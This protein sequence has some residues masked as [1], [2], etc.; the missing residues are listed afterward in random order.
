MAAQTDS[1]IL[2][3]IIAAV[4]AERDLQKF[5]EAVSE[6]V[7]ELFPE[8]D[9]LGIARY[10][11]EKH[12][13]EVLAVHEEGGGGTNRGVRTRDTEDTPGGFLLK[14]ARTIMIND[15]D[16]FSAQAGF[17]PRKGFPRKFESGIGTLLEH[18]GKVLGYIY[19]TSQKKNAFTEAH[20]DFLHSVRG[21]L[22]LAFAAALAYDEVNQL[23][24]KAELEGAYLRSEIESNWPADGLIGKSRAWKTVLQQVNQVAPTDSTVLITGETGTG[25]EVI[26]RAVH[27]RSRRARKPLIKINCGALP[28]NLVESEL[29]GH[30]KGSFTGAMVRR[31]GR[32]ELADGGTIFLDE[33][34]EM[35]LTLQV[36]LLRVLQEREF[37]RVGGEKPIRVNVRVITATNKDLS[38]EVAAGQ[39]RADLF[40]RLNVFPIEIPPLRLRPEDT[41]ELARYFVQ[42]L[43]ERMGKMPM[44]LSDESVQAVQNYSWPGNVRELE[45]LVERAIIL[46]HGNT[47]D[48]KSLLVPGSAAPAPLAEPGD[49]ISK[50]R[51]GEGVS[52]RESLIEAERSA[53]ETALREC[54]G[55]VG[56]RNG[57]AAML[58]MK[59]QTL[60]SKLKKLGIN[61]DKPSRAVHVATD[62]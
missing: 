47:A 36:K 8:V 51:H 15:M 52:F 42:R 24:E 26:A 29:F 1:P 18:G 43:A 30:E 17:D 61:L 40:Y 28:E 60:Q 9:D 11:T 58:G 21:V 53:I 50:V 32:F 25:K 20:R 38:A 41:V 57:A 48:L 5:V 10:D 6:V 2:D 62:D 59:R 33:I 27:E 4:I 44:V 54:N 19:V 14:T 49:L 35:P 45:H 37:E 12:F 34:G 31:I 7:T 22:S 13:F 23:R 55:V 39:F 56:G 46:A 3:R 16:A